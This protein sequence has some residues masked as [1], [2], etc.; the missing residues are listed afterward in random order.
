MCT[1]NNLPFQINSPNET[2]LEKRIEPPSL[3]NISEKT[4]DVEPSTNDKFATF[5]K[6]SSLDELP[7]SMGKLQDR[8]YSLKTGKKA[9]TTN[10]GDLVNRH[11]NQAP[12][13]PETF[14]MPVVQSLSNRNQS[15]EVVHEFRLSR[16]TS[17]S[18][19]PSLNKVQT[20][21]KSEV[22]INSGD[23]PTYS[24]DVPTHSGRVPVM[25]YKSRISVPLTYTAKPV[26]Q[27]V[28]EVDGSG[29]S[30]NLAHAPAGVTDGFSDQA[31]SPTRK[32]WDVESA[33]ND[34]PQMAVSKSNFYM[35]QNGNVDEGRRDNSENG[36]GSS[37]K[38]LGARWTSNGGM[39][40]IGEQRQEN[41][42][43]HKDARWASDGPTDNSENK[44]GIS[45][46]DREESQGTSGNHHA[47][48]IN[49]G[50][51]DN[52]QGTM[53]S[54]QDTRW[55]N[56]QV[57]NG[58]QNIDLRRST[59]NEISERLEDQ[60]ESKKASSSEKMSIDENRGTFE[61]HPKSPSGFE[62]ENGNSPI[63][64]NDNDTPKKGLALFIGDQNAVGEDVSKS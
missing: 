34:E 18:Q 3:S 2:G 58:G 49:G 25:N 35:F 41:S 57:Y 11:T 16:Q 50:T 54:D 61:S 64:E 42:G 62:G 29:N 59:T 21:P 28:S 22:L 6:Q 17:G 56:E 19:D 13:N 15:E 10:D 4:F 26:S 38:G 45:R 63:S 53:G 52:R 55:I 33:S 32:C 51:T 60:N 1:N 30:A 7:P 44:H 12:R 40:D 23:L 31:S 36:G 14:V 39:T 47:Q 48:W 46:N 27:D 8:T 5:T 37:G 9:L 24:G 43:N 20:T